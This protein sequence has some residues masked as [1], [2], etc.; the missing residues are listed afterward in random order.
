[1]NPTSALAPPAIEPV[2]ADLYDEIADCP[3][4]ALARTRSRTVPGMGPSSADVMFIGEAP[5]AR[6]DER[7]LPFVGAAGRF[8]DDLL[9]GIG[10]SRADVYICNVVK[11]RPPGN[12]DPEPE[13]IGACKPFLDR[14]IAIVNPRVIVTLGRFSMARWFPGMA[15]SRIHGKASEF[16]GRTVVPMY[17][18]AAAL[19][20][21]DLRAVIEA[22]F[23]QLPGLIRPA[24]KLPG[25][26]AVEATDKADQRPLL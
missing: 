9:A 25:T 13:E 8:L 20:R 6:E 22:D 12:R 18:P 19:H 3:R 24:S 11:C 17:H 5:G 1:M 15:I 7:G 4:C 14:Q 23:A 16:D 21:G 2:F 26:N 10:L